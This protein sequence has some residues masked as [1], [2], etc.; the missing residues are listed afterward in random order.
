MLA[1]KGAGWRI[2]FQNK[3][4]GKLALFQFVLLCVGLS[5]A[6]F[7]LDEKLLAA[8]SHWAGEKNRSLLG[9][10]LFVEVMVSS[11]H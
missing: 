8:F 4:A 5:C 9:F 10:G 7:R 6:C 11:L 1:V 3:C 2:A